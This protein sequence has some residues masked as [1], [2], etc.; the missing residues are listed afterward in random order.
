MS[1]HHNTLHTCAVS[2]YLFADA[3]FLCTLCSVVALAC[4]RACVVC[5]HQPRI[6][7]SHGARNVRRSCSQRRSQP[8]NRT[9]KPR[10]GTRLCTKPEA[11]GGS[12]S[13]RLHH[14]TKRRAWDGVRGWGTGCAACL[15]YFS[16]WLS[17]FS[18]VLLVA[19]EGLNGA[20]VTFH[21][22]S[23]HYMNVSSTQKCGKHSTFTTH[24]FM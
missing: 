10:N 8:A 14:H 3:F 4:W 13:P 15:W 22:V 23:H 18:S 19:R 9:R 20:C 21:V 24:T 5:V 12:Q 17:A 16:L 6:K 2:P 7:M 1:N 11:K